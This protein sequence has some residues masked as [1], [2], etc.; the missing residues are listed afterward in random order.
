LSYAAA[1]PSPLNTQ[2]WRVSL[3]S[4]LRAEIFIE[5]P[6]L[7]PKLD[8][9]SHQAI[10]S[11]GAFIENFDLASRQI[12]FIPD[13]T[14]FP[15]GW[16]EPRLDF[17]DPV[18]RLDLTW[19]ENLLEDPLFGQISSRRSDRRTYKKTEISPDRF[20]ILT[21]SFDAE[22]APIS[23]GYTTHGSLKD[24]IAG[25]LVKAMEIEL[26]DHARFRETMAWMRS[27]AESS[28]R[29]ATGL[30]FSQL[31]MSSISGWYARLMVRLRNRSGKDE[32][33]KRTLISLTRKQA[34]S[35]AAFG[36]ITTKENHRI[37]QVRA[38]RAYE[39]VHLSATSIGLSLQPMT[40]IIRDYEDMKDLRK[41]FHGILG[42]PETHTIQMFFRL[43]YGGSGS[44]SQRLSPAEFIL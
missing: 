33:L 22:P 37:G 4:S 39:R 20:G 8:P 29:R 32:I 25:Y 7:L 15:S 42:I 41:N 23:L 24:E 6:R 34:H 36:W 11:I 44:S 13:I 16:P 10:I 28:E 3:P 17:K 27:P 5:P 31:G 38:G 2:P 19:N 43:G 9:R 26:S 30:T 12:G 40:Q 14:Y 1:A 35:A 18:A 21:S